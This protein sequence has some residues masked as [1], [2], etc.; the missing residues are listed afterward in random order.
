MWDADRQFSQKDWK[1]LTGS[2]I[3]QNTLGITNV[4]NVFGDKLPIDKYINK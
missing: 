3:W 2:V 4:L 1:A